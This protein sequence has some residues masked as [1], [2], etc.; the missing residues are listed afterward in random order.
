MQFV[1]V[2]WA[3]IFV[4]AIIFVSAPAL[5][6][7]LS[8][9]RVDLNDNVFHFTL[10]EGM[11]HAFERGANPLDFWSPEWS[12]GYPV[13]R[14]YQPLAHA[15]VVL[16]Y[17]ALGKAV[18]LMTVFVWVR[19]L[20]VLLLPLTFFAAARLLAFTEMEAAA[21]ALLAPLVSTNFLY[22]IEFGSYVWAGSGLFTQAIATHFLLLAIGF[23]Y[24]AVRRGKYRSIA[25]ILLGLTYL[26][27]FI[28][29]YIGALTICLAAVLPASG[30]A[31]RLRAART[32]WVGAVAFLVAAFEL[33][34]MLRDGYLI[35]H[36]RW[37]LVWKW[38]SFGAGQVLR[39]LFSGELLDHSRLPV[40]SLLALGGALVCVRTARAT[41]RNLFLVS[42]AVLWILIFFGRPFWGPLLTVLGIPAD[43]PLHRAIGGVHIFLVLLAAAG[44]TALCRIL[45][46]RVHTAAA[47]AVTLL[48]LYP[49]VH[50]RAAFLAN[51]RDWGK[52]NLAAYSAE[53]TS[54]DAVLA[55]VRERGGRAYAGLAAGWG[56][57]F[58]IGD[59]P[60]YAF[61]S[62]AQQ[63]A[64]AFLYHSMA[65]TGDV[66]V[67]FNE[68]NPAQ[69]RVFNIRS[70]V[71]PAQ[72]AALPPFLVPREQIGPYR[73]LDAPGAGY[74]DVVDAPAVVKT[75][76]YNFYDVNE[77]WLESGSPA[78]GMHLR[79]DFTGDSIPPP[80]L[81]L[82][83]DGA[84]PAMPALPPAGTAANE[85][86]DR[87]SG[88]ADV[89]ATRPGFVLFRMTWHPNW[90]AYLDGHSTPTRML[91]PGFIGVPVTL[92]QHHVELRYEPG[93]WKPVM[94][95]GGLL[96]ALLLAGME[97]RGATLRLAVPSWPVPKPAPVL[98]ALALALPV[99]TNLVTT[100]VP[101]GHDAFEYFPRL[102]EFDQ[103]IRHGILFPRWAPDLSHGSGQ[104]LF[105]FNPPMVYY[106]A[107]GWRLAGFD[108]ITAI[109]LASI[110]LVLAAALAM[111]LLGRLYFGDWGGILA[112]A[113]YLYAP[114][115]SVNL[116]VRSALAEFAAF[117]FFALSL[118]GFGA[119]AKLRSRRYLLLGAAAYGGV[120]F[121]HNAAALLFTPLLLGFLAFTAWMARSR[122]V[123]RGQAL[124]F[125]LGLGL[126]ACIWVPS[127]IEKQYVGLF[128]LLQGYLRYTDHFVY[129]HQ[130]L[131]SPWGYGIS[132]AGD[133]DGMSFALGWSHLLLIAAAWIWA[134][135]RGRP[136]ERAWL[137]F[138]TAAA[139][140][141]CL[142]AWQ[143]AVWLW[144]RVALLQYVQFPW[145]LLGVVAVC[146]SLLVAP[147]GRFAA[148]L[149]KWR[150]VV[151][152]G[153]LALLVVPN[154]P[155]NHP[156]QLDEVD[157]SFWTPQ[158]IGARGVEVTTASE[159]APRWV[160]LWPAYDPRAVRLGP[161]EAVVR[162]ESRTPVSW[163]GQ[164][165]AQHATT[166][167]TS[168]AW[169][170]GWE[171]RID[172][173]AV[174]A[175]PVKSTGLLQF[176]MPAGAHH[177]EIAW[178]RTTP[179]LLA[180]LLSLVSLAILVAAL[181]GQTFRL[182]AGF[183]AATGR[184]PAL[185][186]P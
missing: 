122:T 42:A 136:A 93:N 101:E 139:V 80:V 152:T 186:R 119:Y 86:V 25:G 129:L 2:L 140:V 51:N 123:L 94:A 72:G 54:I 90:K 112:A 113:A 111:F 5:W 141:L 63:P 178:K 50:E 131:Y 117:P 37:E 156:K 147:L 11:V 33:I 66:M 19:F 3:R 182:P 64:V 35:N 174:E 138:F 40:L 176:P 127:L 87:D 53:H 120:L 128:R 143:H 118:Y 26:A 13:L 149:P 78:K 125:L 107:E 71:A 98:L 7:D 83:P 168:F 162:E 180:D 27:H 105:E 142:A 173:R 22:G 154:L 172:G 110:V 109:N 8:I 34:P 144:D 62:T 9:S 177:V 171:V 55:K 45:A 153:L 175:G 12:L 89:T 157:L 58:K 124:G 4:L 150:A 96:I 70:V 145:R 52:R 169:F 56:G 116:Y 14:T 115:F 67:R 30:P 49:M 97:W 88:S 21:A 73:V 161:N 121:S 155:H 104:P 60:F 82:P 184:R 130:L 100:R 41:E 132:V 15:L 32:L 57:Q 103:N 170:P 179:R 85:R 61:F 46:S 84:L 185:Q 106:I 76:R 151:L 81:R 108:F 74:F 102:V 23:G 18:P 95:I 126:G 77:R 181:V 17:F 69:Y 31:F 92:G 135:R 47:V 167:Q 20:S 164:I 39:W 10:I 99:C 28:Y 29:G 91:S 48:L 163:S 65:L 6:P 38:D 160:E 166:T 134:A 133:Q 44:L 75:T 158:Q 159:Y 16:A 36:S 24:Q 137:R 79:L 1:R 59:V 148:A 165:E 114:Y 43:F 183:H 146:T 68:W